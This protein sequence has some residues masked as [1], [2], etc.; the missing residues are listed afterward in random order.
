[1]K[2]RGDALNELKAFLQLLE[3]QR[4]PIERANTLTDVV[5]ILSLDETAEDN[6]SKMEE[7]QSL[8]AEARQLFETSSHTFGNIDLDLVLL[9]SASRQSLVSAWEGFGQRLRLA[10]RYYEIDHLQNGSRCLMNAISPDMAADDRFHEMDDA[11]RLLDEKICVGGGEMLR[12]VSLLHAISQAALKA[13]E[14]GFALQ[15]LESYLGNLPA[16]VSPRNHYGMVL[17]LAQVY[18]KFGKH[19]AALRC[20][21]EALGIAESGLPYSDQS[22]AA[23]LEGHVR[24]GMTQEHEDGSLEQTRWIT[25]TADF[26]LRWAD[27]DAEHG[28]KQNERLKCQ[29]IANWENHRLSHCADPNEEAENNLHTW[30]GRAKATLTNDTSMENRIEVAQ[31]E[32]RVLMRKQKFHESSNVIYDLLSEAKTAS[33]VRLVTVAGLYLNASIQTNLWAWQT[34][35]ASGNAEGLENAGKLLGTSLRLA[36]AALDLYHRTDGVDLVTSCTVEVWRQLRTYV[37]IFPQGN[38]HGMLTAFL[39]EV[40]KTEKIVD[41]MRCS[42]VPIQGMASLMRKR[43]L[44]AQESCLKLLS[45]GVE[46]SLRLGDEGMIWVWMQKGKSRAFADALGATILLPESLSSRIAQ[47]P[48]A[49]KL[50]HE[51]QMLLEMLAGNEGNH[52]LVSRRLAVLRTNMAENSLLQEVNHI[53][54]GILDIDIGNEFGPAL[55]NTGLNV[56]QVKFVDWFVPPM[57]M[58]VASRNIVLFVRHLNGTTH[59]RKLSLSAADVT[60]WLDEA[61]RYPEMSEPPLSR[62]AGNR[63]LKKMNGLVE[64]LDEL[65]SQDDL[66]VLTP[67]GLMKNLP[68]HALFVQG[69]SLID[70]N[71]VVYAST[72]STFRQILFRAPSSKSQSLDDTETATTDNISGGRRCEVL[73]D[74]NTAA[75]IPC[76]FFGVYEEPEHVDEREA[77][78]ENIKHISSLLSGQVFLGPEATKPRFLEQACQSRWMHYHGHAR[79]SKD[80]VKSSLCLSNGTD[81]FAPGSADDDGDATEEEA[82]PEGETDG[83]IEELDVTELFTAKLP[84]GMHLTIIACDSGRQESAPGDEPLGIVPAL[85]YAGASSVLGTIWPIDS[86]TGR[87]FSEAFYRELSTVSRDHKSNDNNSNAGPARE[88]GEVLHVAK[89]LQITIR[90]MMKGELGQDLRQPYH[91]AAF[92]VHGL[93]FVNP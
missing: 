48:E 56:A 67:P 18:Q 80:I 88:N 91:W 62:G 25:D 57:E 19:E 31:L 86:A 69:L 70:R 72:V 43:E 66:L 61:F 44:V 13:P 54:R 46:V 40:E 2:D 1:M 92:M 47:D 7:Q 42:I 81:V 51:E 24:Y 21:Q 38:T 37:K 3:P 28:L 36:L 60:Q 58:D 77:I 41:R 79:V 84:A 53:K 65:T 78:F 33:N 22:D 73:C 90:R 27:L 26:L 9:D 30:I 15:C 82:E 45:I 11:V 93:W 20:A 52:V 85:L 89:A 39:A 55:R 17:M 4:W 10:K 12:Q 34:I 29:E 59:M 75:I 16:E 76:S 6:P 50:V 64:G 83:A 23:M 49:R 5:E 8:V 71:L 87:K 63:L 74:D 68:L 35:K 32:I 14:F